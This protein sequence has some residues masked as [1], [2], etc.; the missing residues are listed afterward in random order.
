VSATPQTGPWLV[1]LALVLGLSSAAL[2]DE[3]PAQVTTS[4]ADLSGDDPTQRAGAALSLGGQR[5]HA[6][7]VAPALAEALHDPDPTVRLSAASALRRLGPGAAPA[8]PALI[9]ALTL[10]KSSE[11]R[12]EAALALGAAGRAGRDALPTLERALRDPDAQV[13]RFAGLALE[14]LAAAARAPVVA[15][16]A[17]GAGAGTEAVTGEDSREAA[18]GAATPV[19]AGDSAEP[20]DGVRAP[21]E[22]TALELAE[23]D[24]VQTEQSLVWPPSYSL[25]ENWALQPIPVTDLYPRYIADPRR[26]RMSAMSMKFLETDIEDG[27]DSRIG[28]TLGGRYGFL[29]LHPKDDEEL[30]FQVDFE[31]AILTQF[32]STNSLDNLGWDGFYGLM[33][34]WKP[35]HT[36]A[37]KFAAN[38]DSSHLG[39]EMMENGVRER[40]N[41]TRE[42]FALGVAYTPFEGLRLYA[43]AGFAY[44]LGNYD[45]MDRWRLQAGIEYESPPLFFGGLAG[46]YAAV[47]NVVWEENGWRSS[48]TV[49]AGIRWYIE[50][51][52]REYRIGVQFYNGRSHMGEYFQSDDRYI[53][54]GFWFDL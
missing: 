19:A 26:P 34:S 17:D 20:L 11:V 22:V 33:I 49:Q 7:L 2:A 12:G 4:L 24:V 53:A 3:V 42:E 30:G 46:L 15:G 48:T 31:A 14:D 37:F 38:H 23:R 43:E 16:A 36:L 40:L 27:G 9:S 50:A 47:D 32:D 44:H 39:D 1:G 29:R 5:D 45:L 28:V 10:D 8:V 21:G 6:A 52:G 13:R 25:T 18:A 41:Y 54:F 51:I 35:I